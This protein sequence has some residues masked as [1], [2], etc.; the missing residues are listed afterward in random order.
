MIMAMQP[1]VMGDF[2]LPRAL[3]VMGWLCTGVMAVAVT[4]MFATWGS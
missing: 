2:V 1:K 4:I 3:Q